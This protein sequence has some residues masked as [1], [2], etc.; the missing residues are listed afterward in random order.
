MFQF[1]EISICPLQFIKISIRPSVSEN[2]YFG[3]LGYVNGQYVSCRYSFAYE[4]RE[5]TD[6]YTEKALKKKKKRRDP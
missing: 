2:T 4:E 3:L 6:N 5:G 1:Q